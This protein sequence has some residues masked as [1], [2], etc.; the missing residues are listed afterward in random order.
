MPDSPITDLLDISDKLMETSAKVAFMGIAMHTLFTDSSAY[1][2]KIVFGARLIFDDIETGLV[3][4]ADCA[5][6]LNRQYNH[7]EEA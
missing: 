1:S 7:I 4:I 3:K 6:K 5:C 2:E